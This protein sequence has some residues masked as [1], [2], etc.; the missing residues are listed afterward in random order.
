MR[1]RPAVVPGPDRTSI[2]SRASRGA[3]HPHLGNVTTLVLD[4]SGALSRRQ[5]RFWS[6]IGR[7]HTALHHGSPAKCENARSSRG[8]T[9]SGL[10]A[11]SV[12]MDGGPGPAGCSHRRCCR[13]HPSS[14]S[15]GSRSLPVACESDCWC[16]RLDWSVFRWV[17]PAGAPWSRYGRRLAAPIPPKG[18]S[19]GPRRQPSRRTEALPSPRRPLAQST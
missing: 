16:Q 17:T 3:I 7:R 9:G 2:S 15:G 10:R 4:I 5:A 12:E 19:T 18:P 1:P 11:G 13:S 8:A 14:R 6:D